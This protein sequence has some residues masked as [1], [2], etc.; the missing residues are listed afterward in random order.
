MSDME[1]R[2]ARLEAESQIRQLI[3]HY[4]F[5]I[6]DRNIEAVRNLFTD[7]GILKSADGVMF[8]QGPDAIIEQY[9]GRFDVLGPGHHFMHD[10]QIDFVG[11]G[12][13]EATGRVSGHAELKR[14]GMMMVTALRYADKYRNTPAGWK[15]AEREI[16]FLYYV[17]VSEYPGILLRSDRNLAY[18]EPGPADFPE[19]LPS[20]I[21]YHK[22]RPG[23]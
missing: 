6:D 16:Q 19:R 1:A 14:K 13:V 3:A 22:S 10:V 8:A 2:I 17:P 9:H 12:S 4:C 20:W 18:D 15:F 7:D 5:D 23:A 11:D 21:E